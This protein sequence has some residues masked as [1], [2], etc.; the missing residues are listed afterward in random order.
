MY[1]DLKHN[2]L[3]NQQLTP[4]PIDGGKEN[5]FTYSTN[6]AKLLRRFVRLAGWQADEPT[7]ADFRL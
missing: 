6:V 2:N 3:K 7:L 4:P 1:S 5:D